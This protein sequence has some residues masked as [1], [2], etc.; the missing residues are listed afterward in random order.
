MPKFIE[1]T[2]TGFGDGRQVKKTIL[3]TK[4][5]L[6]VFPLDDG[7]ASIGIVGGSYITEESYDDISIL[8]E[9]SWVKENK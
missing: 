3:N 5:I 9:I 4:Y 1:I 7:R 6:N 2:R 8:L